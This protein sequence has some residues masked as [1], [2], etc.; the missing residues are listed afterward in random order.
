MRKTFYLSMS[1]LCCLMLLLPS[2]IDAH[3][4]RT[5]S[6]GG[7]TC[8]TN[9][10]KWGLEDGEYHYHNGGG[11]SNSGSESSSSG[12][13]SGSGSKSNSPPVE[14]STSKPEPKPQPK[15]DEKQVQA[16]EH[17]KKATDYFNNDKYYEAL[18]ELDKI[19]ELDRDDS[20]TNELIQNSLTAIYNSA[21]AN[22]DDKN[23]EKPKELLDFILDY[24]RSDKKLKEKADELLKEVIL[25]EEID[26]LLSKAKSAQ[27]KKKYEEAISYIEEANRLKETKDISTLFDTII[28]DILDDAEAAY[29]KSEFENANHLYTLLEKHANSAGLEDD[30]QAIIYQIHDL[31][32][33]QNKYGLE[34]NHF[35]GDSLF[36]QL[37]EG[38]NETDYNLDIVNEIKSYLSEIKEE[39]TTFIYEI[40]IK[41]L[42]SGGQKNE[43]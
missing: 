40:N 28:N 20:K 9:C 21:V 24:K 29:Q 37:T 14:S 11:S 22:L 34:S 5:D 4:G 2:I 10:A 3:P 32:L 1:M 6:N 27:D 18:K 16:D 13:S 23:Y 38:K 43:D 15:I 12:S 7:H 17:Y 8:R 19:Y 25:V 35:N 41:E 31:Q 36:S 42:L 33:I 39:V 26:N 30:Y